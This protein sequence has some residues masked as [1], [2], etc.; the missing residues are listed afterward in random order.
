[1][2]SNAALITPP[3]SESSRD[4][5]PPPPIS[6]KT[7]GQASAGQQQQR[8]VSALSQ[9][10][11]GTKSSRLMQPQQQQQQHPQNQHY[12]NFQQQKQQQS[13]SNSSCN[14]NQ[15][16]QIRGVNLQAVGF[17]HSASS[18]ASAAASHASIGARF[19]NV[20]S[21]DSHLHSL[22]AGRPLVSFTPG[23]TPPPHDSIGSQVQQ[24][25]G[26]SS[27]RNA[28]APRSFDDSATLTSSSAR[29]A[30][31]N[32]PT[33]SASAS[34]GNG[35]TGVRT[36]QHRNTM[37]SM[38]T[39]PFAFDNAAF[40]FSN[41]SVST[42]SVS[43]SGNHQS[44]SSAT[45]NGNSC[46]DCYLVQFTSGR[47]DTYF[48]PHDS[49][50]EIQVGDYVVVEADRGEDLG[51][52]IMDSINVP[53]PR[54]NSTSG[55]LM[56]SASSDTPSP[57]FDNLDD[58]M[59]SAA[60]SASSSAS[61]STMPKKIYRRAQPLEIES[62]LGKVRDEVNAIAVGQ[63][64]VQEWKLPMVI[65]DAEYQW[66]R[67]KLTFFFSVTLPS[68]Y[69][70]QPSP[71]I[72]FRTLVRDLYQIY[73]TRI[74]MY[75]VDKDKNRSNRAHNREK[76][77]K[78]LCADAGNSPSNASLSSTS[79]QHQNG[80]H[81]QQHQQVLST[82]SLKAVLEDQTDEQ[83]ENWDILDRLAAGSLMDDLSYSISDLHVTR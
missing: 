72:D 30:M 81:H 66:D 77:L 27:Y 60:Q 47:T 83:N 38:P 9:S 36:S 13:A 23:T 64:K 42:G 1:M 74:W 75:C 35:S 21:S 19:S 54:R 59:S 53:L 33:S 63:Y 68:Y 16:Q 22:L 6:F 43:G 29:W 39:S 40:A 5:S 45:G 58:N 20:A 52:V 67:R 34:A 56:I 61:A 49:R 24:Q 65:I 46:L 11:N 32:P 15:Q 8:A 18:N 51:R 70:N 48:I 7:S 50:L 14:N 62:L 82:N 76:F 79:L 3:R 4:S 73:R 25:P 57:T 10:G 17:E 41:P 78:Q 71:R 26:N 31:Y 28:L 12:G 80:R 37:P 2:M 55:G 44:N 69:P